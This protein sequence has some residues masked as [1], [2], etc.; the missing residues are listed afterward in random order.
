MR[1]PKEKTSDWFFAL[2]ILRYLDFSLF[3]FDIMW[4]LPFYIIWIMVWLFLVCEFGWLLYSIVISV[5]IP[6][7]FDPF[8]QILWLKILILWLIASIKNLLRCVTSLG[9][10]KCPLLNC[11]VNFHYWHRILKTGLEKRSVFFFFRT[12]VILYV[13]E[14]ERRGVYSW[15]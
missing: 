2:F 7:F 12:R 8:L 6:E 11:F 13:R 3:C 14:K 1:N 5:L 9:I 4:L 15:G 10:P